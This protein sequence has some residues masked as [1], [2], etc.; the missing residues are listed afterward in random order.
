[1]RYATKLFNPQQGHTAYAALWAQ[2]KAL[3]VAGHRL[4]V[5]VKTET[6]SLAQNA[7]MWAMLTDIANQVVWHGQ[8]LTPEDWKT[9]FSAS[10]KKQRV[11]PGI[12]GGFVVMGDRTS[13]MT[14]GEM[15]DLMTLMEAFG[16]ERDVMFHE[17]EQ[18]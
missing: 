8:K 6:R 7:R 2:C 9:I 17:Q 10:L 16:A 3:L 4:H 14:V 11:L 12:D 15:S 18:A 5:T 1:M 13:Q